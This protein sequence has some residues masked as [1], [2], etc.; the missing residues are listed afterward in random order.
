MRKLD[1]I[2]ELGTALGI[3]FGA[4]LLFFGLFLISGGLLGD[5]MSMIIGGPMMIA[6]IIT[7]L[8]TVRRFAWIKRS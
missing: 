1:W 2:I 7:F 3:A 6:G 5:L 8:R 4:T